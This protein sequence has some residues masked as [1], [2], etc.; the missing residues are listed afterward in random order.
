M[1]VNFYETARKKLD[2]AVKA[3]NSGKKQEALELYTT[4]VNWLIEAIR[5][6]KDPSCAGRRTAAEDK[7]EEYLGRLEALKKEIAN[8]ISPTPSGSGGAATATRKPG[9]AG[10]GGAD[11][12][13]KEKLKGALSG[14]IVHEKPN[15]KWDDVAG[16][17]T[18]KESLKEAVILPVK[19]PQLFT[20]KREPWKGILLYGPPGTGKS[21]LAKAVATEANATFFSISSADLMSKWQGESERSVRSLFEMAREH[22]P[23]IIFIDEID[24]LCQ[25][26]GSDSGGGESG[27]SRRVLN[28][29]LVQMD[30]VGNSMDGVLF[31]GATNLPWEIDAAMR[32]RFQKRIYIALPESPARSHMFKI[33]VGDTPNNLTH[34][35]WVRLG[36][37]TEGYSG[38]DIKNVVR[39]ALMEPLRKCQS[40]R[41]FRPDFATKKMVPVN[42][43]DPPC[44]SCVPDLSSRPA[45]KGRNSPPCNNCGCIRMS[46]YDLEGDELQ[47]PVNIMDDFIRALSKARPAMSNGELEKYTEFTKNFGQDGADHGAA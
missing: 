8:G 28:E 15:V 37:L 5:F 40:A 26:R 34:D 30:G 33:S 23:S 20:G 25:S 29:F 12:A 18:A 22:K 9:D 14:A 10:G 27:T 44:S 17:E 21:Y 7:V 16:L 13:D 36:D 1:S 2:D 6:D 41:F 24:S 46:L 43:P 3:D 31:L 32:R 38:S 35:D 42:N 4:G 19:F 45:P 47:A 39:E 11:D